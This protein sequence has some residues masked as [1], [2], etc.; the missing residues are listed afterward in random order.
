SF[1]VAGETGPSFGVAGE[2]RPSFGVAGETGPSFGVAD[3]AGSLLEVAG[4]RAALQGVV[5]DWRRDP[6]GVER[7]WR[8]ARD[9]LTRA[10]AAERAA[11]AGGRLGVLC[12]FTGRQEEGIAL[13]RAEVAHVARHG[14]DRQRSSAWSRLAVAQFAGDD[15]AGARE[16]LDR[17]DE[18]AAAADAPRHLAVHAV[19]RARVAMATEDP[20]QALASATRARDFFRAHGPATRTAEAALMIADLAEEPEQVVEALGEVLAACEPEVALM[21]HAHRGRALLHLDRPGEAV[22]DLV[23]A[24]ALCAE[25]DEEQAAAFVRHDLARAYGGAGRP[26]EAAEVAEEALLRFERL[27]LDAP[28]DDV[29]FLLAGL[30]REIGDNHGAL[31][32][33]RTLIERLDGNPAGRGQ[34][35]EQA[36]ALLYDLDRDAEAAQAFQAAARDLHEAGDVIGELRVLRRRVSALHYADDAPAALAAADEAEKLYAGLPAEVAAEPQAVWQR[37][38]IAREAAGLLLARDRHAEAVAYL[39]GL[40]E[41][42]RAIGADDDA[43]RAEDM[44]GQARSATDE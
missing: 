35:G 13:V 22:A 38:M 28:A 9:L 10:G 33:Y 6:E 18:F 25:F 8:T 16:S 19:W 17:A 20:E 42:L 31:S 41:R 21:A 24:A 32:L 37:S 15:F 29:R 1:G 23:E 11:A 40:P 3:E 5:T 26:V 7:A 44:L 2:A 34:V 39:E 4:R 30:Y 14:D 43:A 12:C 27:E 36:G